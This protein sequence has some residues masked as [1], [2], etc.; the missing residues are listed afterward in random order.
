MSDF[1]AKFSN[2]WLIYYFWYCPQVIVSG[3]HRQ[4]VNIGSGD[5]LVPSGNKQLSESMLTQI[6][7]A[8]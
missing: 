7:V 3:S 1:H 4:S 2:G 6:Y 8:M 5:G